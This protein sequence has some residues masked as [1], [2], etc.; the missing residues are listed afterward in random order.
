MTTSVNPSCELVINRVYRAP[1]DLVLS[2]WSKPEF[3][4]NWWGPFGFSTTT[5]KIEFEP[6]GEWDFTMHGPDGTDYPNHIRYVC[7]G[8][9]VIEY[10]HSANSAHEDGFH[11]IVTLEEIAPNQTKMD[12][13]MIFPSQEERDRVAEM[14]AKQ[15]LSETT[16][17]LDIILGEKMAEKNPFEL[18]ISLPSDLEIKTVRSL[19]APK[20][21]V[22]EAYT[23]A[24]YIRR[25]MGPRDLKCLE[26]TFDARPGGKWT[27][28][29]ED[30]T[31][32]VWR[33]HG[34]VLECERPNKLVGTFIFEDFPA[35]TNTTVFEEVDGVTRVTNMASFANQE[36]RDGMLNSGMDQGMTQGFERLEELFAG[37]K[38]KI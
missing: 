13:R 29:H 30:P 21:L 31:G 32:N 27:M 33:F 26:C 11:V 20:E 37:S 36:S 6:G 9:D 23:N 24:D 16:T 18:V 22:Y 7:T 3:L 5:H 28:A 34:E 35:H 14:G 25:W 15:G 38:V 12:F 4:T 17:R 8:P 1:R 10:K 19:R 2:M